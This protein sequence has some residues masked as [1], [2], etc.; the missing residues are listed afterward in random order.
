MG[1]ELVLIKFS[2]SVSSEIRRILKKIIDLKAG[3]VFIGEGALIASID[4]SLLDELRSIP[5]VEHVG[6]VT[7]K[8]RKVLKLKKRVSRGSIKD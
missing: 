8:R 1:T 3:I 7:V 5:C 4:S 2:M 6:G